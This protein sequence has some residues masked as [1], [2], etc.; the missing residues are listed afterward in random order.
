MGKWTAKQVWE[1]NDY[2]DLQRNKEFVTIR[3]ARLDTY[4][5][6]LSI[7]NENDIICKLEN[8]YHVIIEIFRYAISSDVGRGYQPHGFSLTSEEQT[9]SRIT[10]SPLLQFFCGILMVT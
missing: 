8:Y 2:I 1:W 3:Q 5:G 4:S 7:Y 10:S 6:L 9:T